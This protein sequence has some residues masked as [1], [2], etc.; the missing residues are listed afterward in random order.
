MI[1]KF[2]RTVLQV[3][4]RLLYLIYKVISGLFRRLSLRDFCSDWLLKQS[5]YEFSLNCMENTLMK[6]DYVSKYVEVFLKSRQL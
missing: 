5:N 4:S 2:M 6:V 3:Y 1:P